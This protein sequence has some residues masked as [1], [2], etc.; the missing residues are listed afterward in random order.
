MRSSDHKSVVL[1]GAGHA[2]VGVLRTLGA[3]PVP[4][5]R[6]TLITRV[7]DTP[8]SGMLPG[9]IAG[10]YTARQA[11][12]DTRSL[13]KFAD[14]RLI[15]SEV[16]GLD[17]IRKLIFCS[18]HAPVTYD[19]ASLDIGSTPGRQQI[20]GVAAHAIPVKPVDG[21]LER[22]EG[23]RD[24]VLASGGQ[25]RIGVIGA[26]AGGIELLLSMQRRLLA[27]VRDA[28][29]DP[30]ELTFVIATPGAD[31]L[32][33][34]PVKMR[35]RFTAILRARGV[36]IRTGSTVTAVEDG[37][38]VLNGNMSVPLDEIFWC[39]HAE[40]A[41]WLRSTGLALD[42]DG[43]VRVGPTLQSVTHRHVFAAGDVASIDGYACPKSGVYAVRS[44]GALADNIRALA[45]GTSLKSY[46]PQRDALYLITTGDRYAIGTRNGFTFEGRWV[47]Y[48]KRWIDGRFMQQYKNFPE[49]VARSFG[50]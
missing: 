23:V 19:I 30:A 18:D 2:H 43:F 12:I 49:P 20:P 17:P 4:G 25:A 11:H 36:D 22:F 44:A 16:V 42:R 34:M 1:I 41:A 6:V 39:T 33:S 37:A 26:G 8:Y 45:L 21:F 10:H 27:D 38:V 15:H 3:N 9:M 31:V 32:A 13:A 48:L 46:S 47:W 28:G 5:V 35:R 29:H 50:R 14:A 40:P 24:R 7:L